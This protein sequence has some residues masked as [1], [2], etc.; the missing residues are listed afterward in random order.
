MS[1][2]AQSFFTIPSFI[3]PVIEAFIRTGGHGQFASAIYPDQE[4]IYFILSASFCLLRTL[5]RIR[6]TLLLYKQRE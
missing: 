5:Q 2:E 1:M 4:Y 3:V 6:H